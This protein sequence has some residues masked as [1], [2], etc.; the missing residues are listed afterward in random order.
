MVV[1]RPAS[2]VT[3]ESYPIWRRENHVV[4]STEP[5]SLQLSVFK[6]LRDCIVS[7]CTAESL[8]FFENGMKWMDCV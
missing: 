7:E 5:A 3:A 8:P 1:Q 6:G 2:E 4:F